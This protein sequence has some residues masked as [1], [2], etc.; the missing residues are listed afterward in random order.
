MKKTLALLLAALMLLSLA[1]CGGKTEPTE[2][3]GTDAPVTDAADET[4][5]PDGTEDGT[6]TDAAPVEAALLPGTLYQLEDTDAPAVRALR[7]AGNVVGSGEFNAR[8]AGTTGIRCIFQLNEWV[9]IYPETDAKEGLGVWVFAR[10]ENPDEYKTAQLS[11]DAEGFAAYCDL[12]YDA[13]AEADAP[14]GSFY[15]NP[16]DAEAGYYDLVFALNG[17]ATA[18]VTVRF[19]NDAELQNQS[20]EALAQ[21]MAGLK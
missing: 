16:D 21:L 18:V 1:A 9:E 4:A 10:R 20:D 17:K 3:A 6:T 8:E 19:Y 13:E 7:L 15:L 12:P 14:R 2:P 5:Q 11:E